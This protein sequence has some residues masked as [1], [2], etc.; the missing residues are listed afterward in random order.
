VATVGQV[1]QLVGAVIVLTGFVANQCFGLSSGALPYLLANAVGTGLLAVVAGV[2]GDLGFLLLEGV[3]AVVS[4]VSV[5][6]VVRRRDSVGMR[7][8]GRADPV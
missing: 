6:R 7:P 3:W 2:N 5:A 4:C 8:A 1:V